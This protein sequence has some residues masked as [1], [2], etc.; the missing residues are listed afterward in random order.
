MSCKIAV[1]HAGGDAPL[2][3]IGLV[4]KI[5]AVWLSFMAFSGFSQ[6]SPPPVQD[7]IQ[8][9]SQ[10]THADWEKAPSFDFCESDRTA[11]DVRT[12]QVRMV[13]GSPYNRLIAVD[14]KNLSAEDQEKEAKKLED[15]L[16]E[17]QRETVE[18][19]ARRVARYERDR[20]HDQL[21]LQELT[22]AMQFRFQGTETIDGHETYVLDAIPRP[23]YV[24][25]S[26]ETSV[27]TG[28]HGRLWIDRASYRW[29]KVQAEVMR[30]VTI[31]RFVARVE[32]GTRFELKE[33]PVDAAEIWLP[34]HFSMQ[35]RAK[36][37]LLFPKS[38]QKDET[39]FHH[40]ATGLLS[41]ESCQQP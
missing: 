25:K 29:V 16:R 31:G 36:F 37:L 30:P 1:G 23:D 28:M 26:L 17:R 32:P 33:T 7:I 9:S 15:T 41:P 40:Q 8:R 34:A 13:A 19:H 12:Y 39:Y 18:E 22:V 2:K 14:G 6:Q 3:P 35:S 24:P 4:E 10:V 21:M 38:S 5:S 11:K 20:Q 27:L